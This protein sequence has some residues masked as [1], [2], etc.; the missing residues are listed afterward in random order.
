MNL[1]T[2]PLEFECH[3]SIDWFTLS[4]RHP[5]FRLRWERPLGLGWEAYHRLAPGCWLRTLDLEQAHGSMPAR[6]PGGHLSLAGMLEGHTTLEAPEGGAFELSAG[7]VMCNY[8]HDDALFV[9]HCPSPGRYLMVE[10]NLSP[11]YLRHSLLHPPREFAFLARLGR[12]NGCLALTTAL[13]RCLQDILS[14]PVTGPLLASYLQA[15]SSEF[16]CLLLASHTQPAPAP[17][18]LARDCRSLEK[19]RRLLLADLARPPRL[20]ELGRGIGMSERRL[21]ERFKEYYG[22][23]LSDC[24]RQARMREAERLLDGGG[25]AITQI[26]DALGYEH[27]ANFATAFKR[28]F[29]LTPRAYQQRHRLDR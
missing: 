21:K 4:Q 27:A 2:P 28:E 26:A 29:G 14:P 11:E 12:G 20:A 15:K 25:L 24:L 19:A 18:L 22:Q 3:S 16:L 5:A 13:H 8:R 1:P 7:Q 10:L 17:R 9:D 6:I 23:T